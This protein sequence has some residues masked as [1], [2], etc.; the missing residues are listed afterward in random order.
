VICPQNFNIEES[1]G[2]R[3]AI[4][5]C[6]EIMIIHA[7]DTPFVS[8]ALCVFLVYHTWSS[9]L[10]WVHTRPVVWKIRQRG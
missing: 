7:P 4:E 1:F 5:P 3:E 8:V 9:L 10:T 2:A 6:T